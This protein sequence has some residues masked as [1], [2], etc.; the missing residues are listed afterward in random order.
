MLIKKVVC[1]YRLPMLERIIC[2]V[3]GFR[4]DF[5][6]FK[7]R[8]IDFSYLIRSTDTTVMLKFHTNYL[9]LNKNYLCVFTK[10][11]TFNILFLLCD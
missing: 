5:I 3:L 11:F 9:F 8:F 1:F 7:F 2:F 10:A 4:D 6:D